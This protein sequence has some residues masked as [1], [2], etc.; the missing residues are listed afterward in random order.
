LALKKRHGRHSVR[1]HW[2][3]NTIGTVVIVLLIIEI[4]LILAVRSYYYSA[5]K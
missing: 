1:R 2:L 5:A 4:L 3:I